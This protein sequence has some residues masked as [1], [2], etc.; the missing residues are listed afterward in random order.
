MRFLLDTSLRG[1]AMAGVA[2]IGGR[3][4]GDIGASLAAVYMALAFVVGRSW[5]GTLNFAVLQWLGVRLVQGWDPTAVTPGASGRWWSSFAPA[6]P[7]PIEWHLLRWVWP[8]TGWWCAYRR[9]ARRG[10]VRF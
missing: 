3:I 7:T 4:A 8:L 1:A 2:L 9:I 5:L 10:R 6:R